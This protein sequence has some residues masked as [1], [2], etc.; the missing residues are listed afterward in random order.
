M[1]NYAA[2]VGNDLTIAARIY[3][4]NLSA[5]DVA[6]I[7]PNCIVHHNSDQAFSSGTDHIITTDANHFID[8]SVE[9]QKI[10]GRI[11]SNP[12]PNKVYTKPY[13]NVSPA[14]A[15]RYAFP[16]NNNNN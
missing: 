10:F 3:L 13:G 5:A 15:S 14:M 8:A 7:T 4:T 12:D 9:T 1:N 16:N 11:D 2:A 6:R